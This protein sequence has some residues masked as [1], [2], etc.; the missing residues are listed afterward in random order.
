MLLMMPLDEW[1]LKSDFSHQAPETQRGI[2]YIL[3]RTTGAQIYETWLAEEDLPDEW[4]PHYHKLKTDCVI[5]WCKE[6]KEWQSLLKLQEWRNLLILPFASVAARV[7]AVFLKELAE[8]RW[9]RRAVEIRWLD[10]DIKANLEVLIGS[11]ASSLWDV[12]RFR[13]TQNRALNVTAC[14]QELATASI[15]IASAVPTSTVVVP[16][17]LHSQEPNRLLCLPGWRLPSLNR[18]ERQSLKD[19]IQENR[20]PQANQ[21]FLSKWRNVLGRN[22]TNLWC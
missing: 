5:R 11:Y 19:W 14:P 1:F 3:S 9:T 13:S 20:P 2:E 12:L 18:E 16:V 8:E 17:Y 21:D 4:L 22:A 10:T 6:S 15:L 7:A